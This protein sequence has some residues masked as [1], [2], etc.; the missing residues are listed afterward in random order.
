MGT[1]LKRKFARQISKVTHPN[2]EQVPNIVSAGVVSVALLPPP[3][4]TVGHSP[5][6][7]VRAEAGRMSVITLRLGNLQPAQPSPAQPSPVLGQVLTSPQI[8]IQLQ[9][10]H[11][12]APSL[13][14]KI[15]ENQKSEKLTIFYFFSIGNIIYLRKALIIWNY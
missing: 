10:S 6:T 8:I 12:S 3:P 1:I 11:S 5:G 4:P 15:W 14:R 13:P 7:R 9:Q 2:A